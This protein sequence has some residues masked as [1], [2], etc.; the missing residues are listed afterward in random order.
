M[1]EIRYTEFGVTTII[2]NYAPFGAE[3]KGM[4]SGKPF[5]ENGEIFVNSEK[6]LYKV[7]EV[8]FENSKGEI[9]DRSEVSLDTTT[10]VLGVIINKGKVLLIKRNKPDL[11][12]YV[13]PG[14][15]VRENESFEKAFEREM[16]EETDID[17]TNYGYTLELEQHR[18][19][20]GPEKAFFVEINE[21]NLEFKQSDP[22]DAASELFFHPVSKL[23]E[24]KNVFPGE[25]E[26]LVKKKYLI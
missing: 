26:L 11:T 13:F 7:S 25:V 2:E 18:D 19:G 20:F 8:S 16:V 22:D 1:K 9:I 6:Q 15:H 23:N 24:L 14:G 3:L 12:Y 10:Y 5:T 4:R 21:T 17:V